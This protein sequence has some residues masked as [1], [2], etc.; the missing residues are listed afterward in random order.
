MLFLVALHLHF[1]RPGVLQY[2]NDA[3]LAFIVVLHLYSIVTS[4]KTC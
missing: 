3:V 2:E 1:P 4:N